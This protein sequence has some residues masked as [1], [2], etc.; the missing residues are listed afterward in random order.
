MPRNNRLGRHM[1]KLGG[2]N[3]LP[4]LEKKKMS[5][6]NSTDRL[7]CSKPM[8][9]VQIQDENGR[10]IDVCKLP[11]T[12]PDSLC[13]PHSSSS[14]SIC[15]CPNPYANM[16]SY[17]S[18]DDGCYYIRKKW[19]QTIVIYV[20]IWVLLIFL[21]TNAP[22]YRQPRFIWLQERF[23]NPIYNTLFI[24]R[25][26]LLELSGHDI[27]DLARDTSA[28]NISDSCC[29]SG[30]SSSSLSLGSRQLFRFTLVFGGFAGFGFFNFNIAFSRYSIRLCMS[31]LA[32]FSNSY[33]FALSAISVH[34]CLVCRYILIL[35]DLNISDV[36]SL[37]FW[38]FK[39]LKT[40]ISFRYQHADLPIT[41][42]DAS[43]VCLDAIY[44][45]LVDQPR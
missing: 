9:R 21:H 24:T 37:W 33:A 40:S 4:F 23:K 38:W 45:H 27:Q 2:N 17:Q 19:W 26:I 5:Y 7:Y 30:F 41:S 8:D 25:R 6:S 12:E 3:F 35:L 15:Y 28:L 34:I 11:S 22:N 13:R 29:S 39:K 32:A 20:C 31:I 43:I 18:K 10:N 14:S 44:F 1:N 16:T 36:P 42:K